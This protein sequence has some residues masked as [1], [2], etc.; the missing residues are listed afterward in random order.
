MISV[1]LATG[2]QAA[3]KRIEIDLRVEFNDFNSVES[4]TL[5][6]MDDRFDLILGM[7]WLESHEPWID[8]RT[9]SIGS[10]TPGG[11]K[12]LVSH[13]PTFA[14]QVVELPH[15]V[16]VADA[17][18]IGM[19]DT[20]DVICGETLERHALA[21]VLEPVL[22][23]PPT[24]KEVKWH[25]PL[26]SVMESLAV[27]PTVRSQSSK[28]RDRRRRLRRN[29]GVQVVDALTGQPIRRSS[30]ELAKMPTVHE[31]CTLEELSSDEFIEDLKL[32]KIAEVLVIT[33]A[34]ESAE[35]NTSS[36]VDEAVLV[37]FRR[38]FDSRRV[39]DPEGSDGSLPRSGE[40]VLLELSKPR[41][42]N[43]SSTRS[44]NPS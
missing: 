15:D 39:R 23:P 21:S 36:V 13:E 11:G 1:R 12:V 29:L 14:H 25:E 38:K 44:G 28:R 27:P 42:S 37:D 32:G 40:G 5:L 16:R 3:V 20:T 4:F 7:P 34:T 30:V 6:D 22:V 9:K 18:F 2:A 31:L 35:L 17:H 43:G 19:C 41:P 33:S 8:W 24:K 10:S 26:V